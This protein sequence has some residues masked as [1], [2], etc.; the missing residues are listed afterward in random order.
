[1]RQTIKTISGH[2]LRVF[3][4][5][6]TSA[7]DAECYA[8]SLSL[9]LVFFSRLGG[10]FGGRGRRVS[11]EWRLFCSLFFLFNDFLPRNMAKLLGFVLSKELQGVREPLFLR[12][13]GNMNAPRISN[14]KPVRV[15]MQVCS[16]KASRIV[17][18][19]AQ[20]NTITHKI[21]YNCKGKTSHAVGMNQAGDRSR[22]WKWKWEENKGLGNS[23]PPLFRAC[24][25]VGEV[26]N[27]IHHKT[28]PLAW[29]G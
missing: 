18:D 21:M 10:L 9:S 25:H 13:D 11:Q 4:K 20:I 12:V 22:R 26:T 28:S 29:Y 7:E 8:T 27:D 17:C 3:R 16:K 6:R 15:P 1:M 24:W 19:C 2:G 5:L 23:L 14:A